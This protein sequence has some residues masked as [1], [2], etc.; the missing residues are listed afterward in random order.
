MADDVSNGASS[1]DDESEDS[2]SVELL[3]TGREKRKTAGNRYDRDMV[4]EEAAEEQEPDEVTLLFAA[5]GEEE[6]EEFKSEAS[7][8]D[9]MSS[10]DDD[11][12]GPNAG[13]DELEGEK[14]LEKQVKAEKAKKRK[15]EL[16][17]T[18]TAGLRKRPKVDP[19]Q[20]KPIVKKPSKKKERLTWL[21]QQ[22]A[23][24]A[25]SSLR[26]QTIAHRE[27]TLRRLKESEVQF[28]K[29]KAI[30]EKR[31]K[32]KAKDAPKAMTQADRLAEA[33]RIERRN[34]KSLNRWETMEKKRIEEQAAKLAALKDRK[35]DGAVVTL[36]SGK[37]YYRG[38]RPSQIWKEAEDTPGEPKKRGRKPK[39]YHEHIAALRAAGDSVPVSAQQSPR[40]T[41]STDTPTQSK[42]QTSTAALSAPQVTFAPPQRSSDFFLSGIHE[43][44]SM[45]SDVTGTNAATPNAIVEDTTAQASDEKTVDVYSAE[46]K[47]T[48]NLKPEQLAKPEE[49]D[50]TSVRVPL[51]TE[52]PA[53]NTMTGQPSILTTPLAQT[54]IQPFPLPPVEPI[55]EGYTTKNLVILNKF[56]DAS[57][58]NR[59]EYGMFYNT[60]KSA[61][62]AK[63][64]QELCPI[65]TRPAR[66]RDPGTGIGYHDMFAY[67]VLQE[68]REHKFTW[69]SMLGC[70]IGRQGMTVARGVPEGFSRQ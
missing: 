64:N 12:Q 67:K 48:G 28:N 50:T 61:K 26:M 14:E 46:N 31:E 30:R 17:L 25:R 20:P 1:S 23:A 33:E 65:T 15:A 51:I 40:P 54:P 47:Q 63:H 70:Y 53:N 44:A 69:S 45:Q 6:D 5:E 55:E 41:S 22:D 29:S 36:W 58:T 42:H 9:E 62:P 66:Y 59:Q 7:D 60:R 16:A 27:E 2:Q 38:P 56:D 68:L 19:T 11:D 43:Y 49:G 18:S 52:L 10:S 13:A 39:G 37:A 4:L 8:A 57:D 3:I 21:P 34:A 24:N 32:E 35:L